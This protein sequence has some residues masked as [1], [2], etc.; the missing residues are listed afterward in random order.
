MR[1]SASP[2]MRQVDAARALSE[3]QI[4]EFRRVGFLVLD[5]ARISQSD[6]EWCRNILM[7]LFDKGAG[8]REGR[9]FD[10]SARAGANEGITPQLF[11][12]SLYATELSGWPFRNVGLTIARQLLG[13]SATLAADNAVLKPSRVGGVTPWHQDEAHNDTQSY[14]E[15]ITIWIAMFDTTIAN[16]AMAFIPNSHLHGVLLHRLN[17]GSKQ[18]NSIECCG[19]FDPNDAKA[20]PIPAGGMTIHH[21]R[22]VH[23]AGPNKSDGPRL[24]YI[25]NYKNPPKPRPDLGSFSWNKTVGTSIHRQRKQWRL[26]GGIFIEVVRFLRSDRDNFRHFMMQIAR[27]LKG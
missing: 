12:P 9:N 7:S 20:C 14:Q 16:G 18:A 10:I 6:I 25:L 2:Q 3:E 8:R 27:F 17:G 21:G 19:D 4:A 1:Q 13:P 11:R 24:G 26:R 22:T 15:Q 23:G 5:A